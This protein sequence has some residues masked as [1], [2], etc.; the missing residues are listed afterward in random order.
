MRPER[1]SL[2][3]AG[4]NRVELTALPRAAHDLRLSRRSLR[5]A[6]RQG[7]VL[8]AMVRGRPYVE[9]GVEAHGLAEAIHAWKGRSQTLQNPYRLRK[10]P[11]R[12]ERKSVARKILAAMLA[13][14]RSR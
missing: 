7:R 1:V 5:K 10:R 6:V 12:A 3:V 9:V 2:Q 4:G 13:M 14:G 11:E 8:G